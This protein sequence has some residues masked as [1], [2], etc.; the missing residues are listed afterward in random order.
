MKKFL[1]ILVLLA[2]VA[3][4]GFGAYWWFDLRWRPTEITQQNVQI[5]QLVQQAGWVSPGLNGPKVYMVSFRACPNCIRYEAEEFPALQR[6]GVDTRVIMFAR[7]PGEGG[8]E[9]STVFERATVAELWL[10]R[11]WGLHQRWMATRPPSAW[12]APGIPS[13][14]P[15]GARA[16]VVEGGRTFVEQLTGYLEPNGVDWA[17]PMLIWRTRDGRLMAC[18][19]GDERSWRFVRRDLGV[20]G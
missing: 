5:E 7:R 16:A 14:E 4:A 13:A 3:G 15:G 9:N 17:T 1:G 10:N 19:C 12:T 6:A 11:D 20:E 8:I 2:L 18:A